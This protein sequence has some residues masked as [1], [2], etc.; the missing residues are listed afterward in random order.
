MPFAFSEALTRL[1]RSLSKGLRRSSVFATG[2][3]IASA[4]MSDFVGWSAAES[5]M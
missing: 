3:S 2:S 1:A 4:G 5:W